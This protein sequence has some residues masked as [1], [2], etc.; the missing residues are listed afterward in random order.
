[1]VVVMM[2]MLEV[3]M[4]LMVVVVLLW[5]RAV[6]VLI[7]L[8]LMIT[9]TGPGAGMMLAVTVLSVLNDVWVV[10]THF[11][12]ESEGVWKET[13]MGAVLVVTATPY[14]WMWNEGSWKRVEG[15]CVCVGLKRMV[16]ERGGV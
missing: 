9:V 1:M 3:M 15:A 10:A 11:G 5:L 16:L 7:V 6:V 4:M 12:C 2:R 13:V 14:A 8:V